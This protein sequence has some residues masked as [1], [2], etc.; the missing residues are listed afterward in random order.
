MDK[1]IQDKRTKYFFTQNIFDEDHVEEAP[2]PVFSEQEL[3][4]TR[5]KAIAH[6]KTQGLQE[7]ESS[8]LKITA[9]ILDKIQKQLGQLAAAEALREQMF[10]RETLQLCLAVFE[11]LFP[12]YNDHAGFE[13]L[14]TAVSGIVKQQEGQSHVTISVT[15]D[16]TGA[17]ETHLNTLKDSGLDLKFTVK[18]DDT[19]APGACRLA[20]SDGGALRDPQRLAD[21][22]RL[23]VQQVLA[24][25]GLKGHDE[26]KGES[27]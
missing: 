21:E 16:V 27:S 10:E 22:I 13:E 19:L 17:I 2:P 24:K 9:Q 26:D 3:E 4:A 6:G 14:K 11:R 18:S 1:V 15:P 23:S 12:V 20:W 8:Q 25:K 7:A 5:L